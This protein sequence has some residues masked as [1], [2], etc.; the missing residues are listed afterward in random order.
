MSINLN[1]IEAARATIIDLAKQMLTGDLSYME[2]SSSILA[3]LETARL[4]RLGEFLPFVAIDSEADR[5]PVARARQFWN[6]KALLDLQPEIEKTERWAKTVGEP[7]CHA[8]IK[9]L[10][11]NPFGGIRQTATSGVA[12]ESFPMRRAQN[13][14]ISKRKTTPIRSVS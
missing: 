5:F 10:K 9:N 7:A 2:G 1:E 8:V 11:P 6:P 14:R 12:N 13:S 4:E 3:L